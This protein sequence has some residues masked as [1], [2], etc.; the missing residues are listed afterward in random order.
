V[1]EVATI[2]TPRTGAP[3]GGSGSEINLV[4]A[5]VVVLSIVPVYFAQRLTTGGDGRPAAVEPGTLAAVAG[6]QSA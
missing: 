1:D 2:G 5:V 3:A 6:M 4:A